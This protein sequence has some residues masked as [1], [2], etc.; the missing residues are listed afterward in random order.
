MSV[1]TH[2]PPTAKP[3]DDPVALALSD[4]ATRADLIAQALCRWNRWRA[5]VP[6][7]R[8]AE[9]A[10]DCAQET[11][12]RAWANRTEYDSRRAPIARWLGG[13]MKYV[14]QEYGRKIRKGPRYT[15]EMVE[16]AAAD[17]PD[18][19]PDETFEE[20]LKRLSP[21][22]RDL[23]VWSCVD[24]LSHREIG[25]RLNISESNSRQRLRRLL[26]EL[27]LEM[28]ALLGEGNR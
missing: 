10:E 3:D 16:P 15:G 23:V 8:R 22:D 11:L 28:T 13:I 24:D 14:L 2:P 20:F 9:E 26:A 5:D 12:R 18:A 1:I 17:R 27:R 6:R 25:A 4:P 7:A 21:R 19:S